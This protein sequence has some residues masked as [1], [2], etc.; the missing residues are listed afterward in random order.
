MNAAG[1]KSPPLEERILVL[2]PIP[3]DASLTSATLTEAGI[4]CEVA[5]GVFDLCH[6]LEQG[7]GA[8][9]LAEEAVAESSLDV[10]VDLISRQ[11]PWSDLPIIVITGGG[12]LSD[13]SGRIYRAFGRQGN[14]T[15][16]ERPFRKITL[17]ATVQSALRSRRRQ[18]E[19][20]EL[21]LQ[22][23]ASTVSLRERAAQLSSAREELRQHAA[24]LEERVAERTA[25]L[26]ETTRR[27][28]AFCYT[29]AHDLR[30]P[31]RSQNGY[32][33]IIA[34]E[35]GHLL[36]PSGREYVA[37]IS[38]AA[39]K[40]DKLITDLLAY[41]NLN[42]QEWQ[43]ESISLS[44]VVETVMIDL[45]ERISETTA[46]VTLGNLG[47]HVQAHQAS[48]EMIINNLLSNALKYVRPDQRPQVS[49]TA[50]RRG[51]FIRL[52]V[53]D[54]GIGIAPQYHDKIFGV[55]ERLD[56]RDDYSGTGIGLAIVRAAV[57]RMDG[58]CG[59][60]SA[61]DAGSRFWIELRS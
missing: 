43:L 40:L 35:F 23:S 1:G 38:A 49:L 15:F 2:A 11:P 22:L 17:L 20:R 57:Q 51:D 24:L 45:A 28:N 30:A 34:E 48:L 6:R 10:L 29:V 12:Q 41:A 47:F 54:L 37:K 18:Y 42:R 52:W 9:L 59:V 13:A 60:E 53:Q 36:G 26:E 58:R 4:L 16:L 39:E 5:R 55:F 32:A 33:S 7:C 8:L 14:L 44:R 25:N 31:L 56:H 46:Q 3:Q 21:I 61:L 50:E 19:T 27:L